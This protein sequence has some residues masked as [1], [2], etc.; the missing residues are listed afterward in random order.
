VTL[1][2]CGTPI[3]NLEDATFRL[4]RILQE[5]DLIACEDTRHTGKLLQHYSIQK[6]TISYHHHNRRQREAL[7]IEELK[8]GKNV[9][10]VSDAGMPGISDPG[11]E[12]I[13]RAYEENIDVE[14]IPGPSA[15]VSAL[16]LSGFDSSR[17]VFEGFLPPRTTAR[18]QRLREL[19]TET[20]TI[21]LYEAPH[22][23][24]ELM[25]DMAAEWGS[26]KAAVIREMTKV[27][28]EVRR[29]PLPEL[30]S[31]YRENPARGEITV[32]VEGAS[33]EPEAVNLDAVVMEVLDLMEQG[34]QKKEALKMKALQYRIKRGDIYKRLEQTID[35][36]Q[37]G[38][39]KD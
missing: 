24:L 26:R 18:R 19:G 2:I 8:S 38:K 6:R 34:V 20:R 7:L 13:R 25:E 27:H 4:I 29:G 35:K 12:L 17:F 28:E 14:I 16:V 39:K 36:N 11:Y 22:R 15:L 9:A 5:V 30:I 32:V 23:L 3:G 1:Y 21:I 37:C 10:L 33:P 31:Y